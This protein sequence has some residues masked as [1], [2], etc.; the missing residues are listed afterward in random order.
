MEERSPMQC[1][2]GKI[3]SSFPNSWVLRRLEVFCCLKLKV[4]ASIHESSYHFQ[5][6]TSLPIEGL[7]LTYRL[8]CNQQNALLVYQDLEPDEMNTSNNAQVWAIF[9]FL[10]HPS[11]I[12]LEFHRSCSPHSLM[13]GVK[14]RQWKM[15][16]GGKRQTK[17]IREVQCLP[18]KGSHSLRTNLSVLNGFST[19]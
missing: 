10:S 1:S 19:N 6:L 4:G 8:I 18:N 9:A 14:N 13:K 3:V 17:P 2:Q 16:K 7:M 5:T 11:G 12:F 15:K